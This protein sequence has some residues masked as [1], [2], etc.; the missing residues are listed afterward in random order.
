[1]RSSSRLVTIA[2]SL[3]ACS[4]GSSG[5][6]VALAPSIVFPEGLLDNVTE[7]KVSVYDASGLSCS[8]LDGT[9]TG[10][11]TQMPLA[12]K[13][14][15]ASGCPSNAKFCGS[16]SIDESGSP[17]LFAAQAFVG[18]ASAPIASGCTS[19]IPNQSTLQVQITMLRTPPPQTCNGMPSTMIT[20]C[21]SGMVG[22]PVCD[23]NCQ[24]LEEYFSPGD[25]AST[26]N[27]TSKTR[28]LLTWPAATTDPA[29]QLVGVWG[30]KAASGKEV[31]MRVL[32]D[33]MEPLT[34][35][36]M[37]IQVSSF[38][39][40]AM[41]GTLCPGQLYPIGQFDPTIAAINGTY[42]IAF[43]D[44]SAGVQTINVRSFNPVLV[45]QQASAV[46][47]PTTPPTVAQELPS[48]AANGNN[49]YVAWS[50][51][52]GIV[53]KMISAA[54]LT[55]GTQQ[56]L[57]TVGTN[58]TVAATG[59]GWVAS[60]LNGANVMM[61]TLDGSGNP[62]TPVQVNTTAGASNPGIAA[63][64]S[65]VAVIWADGGGN[66]LVQRYTSL[67]P[68]TPIANDQANALQNPSLMGG[69]GNESQPS[70]AAGT[71]FFVATWVDTASGHVRARFLDGVGGYMFNAVNEQSTDFQAS[72]LNGETRGNPPAV[73]GGAGPFVAIAWEDNMNAAGTGIWGRRFPLPQSQ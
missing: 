61:V 40:P 54:T 53:G 39:M 55:G 62:G 50:N 5:G 34:G 42:Y 35:S 71:N 32:D 23:Q 33:S 15:Q 14:L 46:A 8:M 41:S 70:I 3:F 30:E 38:R 7:L 11:G 12:T 9:V 24:S 73:V 25:G 49:L 56:T 65:T 59:S 18:T 36:S 72:T 37:C 10:L 67:S 27:T 68:L 19:A 64:G 28:P 69:P 21:P 63:F 43:E 48:M 1:M 2:V 44:A 20:Q 57:A 22:D 26:S 58:V 6:S 47:V 45:P 52:T 51:G 17:R 16:I 13:D 4:S 29:G 60:Y 66:I 31:S